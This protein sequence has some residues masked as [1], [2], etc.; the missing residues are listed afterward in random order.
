M[1]NSDERVVGSYYVFP[2]RNIVP[3]YESEYEKW[4]DSDSCYLEQLKDDYVV[5]KYLG[6]GIYQ[7]D[8]GYC[9]MDHAS[10]NLIECIFAPFAFASFDGQKDEQRIEQDSLL[11][12]A[13][14]MYLATEEQN[15]ILC[16][17]RLESDSINAC[18]KYVIYR[19]LFKKEQS[20]IG[21]KY[22]FSYANLNSVYYLSSDYHP[23][24]QCYKNKQ[25]YTIIE[26]IGNHLYR[27]LTTD[28]VFQDQGKS[29]EFLHEAERIDYSTL[30][31]VDEYNHS[32]EYP[33]RILPGSR[34]MITD[35]LLVDIF[36]NTYQN[37][38]HLISELNRQKK[39]AV[40]EYEALLAKTRR[41]ERERQRSEAHSEMESEFALRKR[42]QDLEEARKVYRLK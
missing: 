38:E 5:V 42:K 20:K 28:M 27:D 24:K 13:F 6:D 33:F 17:K 14:Y 25:K 9:I 26:Y 34:L 36:N 15:D 21:K 23:F 40:S 11:R 7:D 3:S 22:A 2:C 16:H 19:Y 32:L 37:R 29:L 18:E 10:T 35:D 31:D 39:I 1:E 30:A 8:I 41:A 4:I 12:R